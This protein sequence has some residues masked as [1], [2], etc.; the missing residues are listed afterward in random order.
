M[1]LTGVQTLCMI[2]AITIGTM[3]TRFLPFIFFPD[4]KTPPAY[5]L[6]LGKV[7]PYAVI[8][9]LVVYCL[10]GVSISADPFALPEIIA[11][12]SIIVLHLWRKN[13]LLSIGLGTAIYMVL[14]QFIFI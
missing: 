3:I 6:Y 11:I 5:I 8:G 14:V 7:L 9:M 1:Y 10:K 2:G 13:T 4:T 12:I